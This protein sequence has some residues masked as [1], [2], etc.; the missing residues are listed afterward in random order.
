[1]GHVERPGLVWV[2]APPTE[3]SDAL[4]RK[5]RIERWFAITM[6]RIASTYICTYNQGGNDELGE[7]ATRRP[8]HGGDL[9]CSSFLGGRSHLQS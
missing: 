9:G 2:N 3:E 7:M 6:F 8:T 1:M 4:L 5:V